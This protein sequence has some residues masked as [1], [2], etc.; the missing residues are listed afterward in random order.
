MVGVCSEG[1]WRLV[2]VLW[3]YEVIGIQS[4]RG[5]F[6]VRVRTAWGPNGAD[7]A[8][9]GRTGPTGPDG[10]GRGRMGP[11]GGGRGRTGADG[12]GRGRTGA[13]FAENAHSVQT[14][15]DR[16]GK[17]GL[18]TGKTVLSD[19]VLG[20]HFTKTHMTKNPFEPSSDS[21]ESV[22]PTHS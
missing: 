9:W 10:A 13:G 8:G 18:W 4:H 20:S 14:G 11:D 5:G 22:T 21:R 19:G 6:G 12:R 1:S 15:P 7:G 3:G 17:N 16:T 2:A